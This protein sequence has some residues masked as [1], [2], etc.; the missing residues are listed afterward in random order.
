MLIELHSEGCG[1]GVGGDVVVGRPDATGGD[2]IVV[3]AA[4]VVQRGDD[5]VHGV[6]HHPGLGHVHAQHAQELRDVAQV[7]V[8]RPP[9]EDLVADD[10]HCGGDLRGRL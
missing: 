1:D 8:L 7:G 6:G 9:R 2:H 10:Q 3:T 5:L 4:Q